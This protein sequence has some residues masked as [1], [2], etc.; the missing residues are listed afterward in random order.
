MNA[1]QVI[2]RVLPA[3]VLAMNTRSIV[4]AAGNSTVSS[5]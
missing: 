1:K 5:P 4:T 3:A 2:L